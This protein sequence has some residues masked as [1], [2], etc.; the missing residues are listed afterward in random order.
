MIK[1]QS[2]RWLGQRLSCVRNI[3]YGDGLRIGAVEYV[4]RLRIT[5]EVERQL[6]LIARLGLTA[7]RVGFV[8]VLAFTDGLEDARGIPL[9]EFNL[10]QRLSVRSAP[11]VGEVEEGRCRVKGVCRLPG[12]AR[13]SVSACVRGCTLALED[14]TSSPCRRPWLVP[15]DQTSPAPT[16]R[17]MPGR[18]CCP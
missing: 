7:F 15:P 5:G 11:F 8:R 3:L 4:L 14:L 18:R 6:R 17:R 13:G 1:L 9:C 12:E 16:V 2:R 10:L